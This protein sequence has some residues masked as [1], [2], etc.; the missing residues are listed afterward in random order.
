VDYV[1]VADAETLQPI[2]RMSK[3]PARAFAA[4]WLGRTRLIDNV[5]ISKIG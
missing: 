5:E 2:D 1:T 3:R 4:A